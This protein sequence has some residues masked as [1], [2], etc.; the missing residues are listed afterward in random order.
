M[1]DGNPGTPST[2]ETEQTPKTDY[3]WTKAF[4]CGA[5]V[6]TVIVLMSVWLAALAG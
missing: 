6:A 3:T 4:A 2:T 5:I 1:I